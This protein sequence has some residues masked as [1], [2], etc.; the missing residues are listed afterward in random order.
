MRRSPMLT[1][2]GVL[3]LKHDEKPM[4]SLSNLQPMTPA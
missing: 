1:W 3:S 2:L 4:S